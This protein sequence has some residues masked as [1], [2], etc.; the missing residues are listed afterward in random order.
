M[1]FIKLINRLLDDIS[2]ALKKGR[3][4]EIKEDPLNTFDS[5]FGGVYDNNQK[6]PASKNNTNSK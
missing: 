1:D 4:N 6:L 5:K 3:E 2:L